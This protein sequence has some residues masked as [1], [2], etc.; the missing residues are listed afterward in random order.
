M[1]FNSWVFAVFFAAFLA[2]HYALRSVNLRNAWILAASYFFYGWLSPL[3]PVL[4]V[5]ATLVSYAAARAIAVSPRKKRWLALGVANGLVLLSVFKYG[6]F[7]AANLNALLGL[8]GL[9][10]AVGPPGKLFPV[11][12]SFY[13]LLII[14]YLVDVARGKA[15]AEKNIVRYAAFTAFF[16]YL[17]AGPIERAGG[18]LP[19]LARAPGLKASNIS[20]GLSLFVVGLF[21][22]VALADFLA[23][24]VNK[25]YGQ[26]AEAAGLTLLVAT[27]AFA[28][29]IYFDFSG[30]TDLA[31]GAAKMMGY[32]L[33]LNFNN[34][35]LADG[36][37]DFWRRWHISLSSWIRDYLYFPLAGR[38]I[39]AGLRSYL[40]MTAAILLAG[41]WHGAAWTFV[42]WGAL[43]ALG[44][45]AGREL[46]LTDFYR[47]RLPRPV[48][49]FFV[50]HWVCL[51][52]I[53]FRAATI[54][55][56]LLILRRILSLTA[57]DPRFPLAAALL[58]GLVL[59]YQLI[60]RSKSRRLL[61]TPAVRIALV[62]AMMLY[63]AFFS[64][65]GYEKFYYFRF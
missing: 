2:V 11:G 40:A 18:M 20:E 34:P 29:Q 37:G 64:T 16:P 41:L 9:E 61:C 17:L 24:Y 65:P 26:P 8:A 50:F 52:W 5:Y 57:G 36:M 46:E 6:A 31:R 62:T 28:W 54:E 32:D 12:V 53:F 49:Q 30:Y 14:G 44:R 22:K 25:V 19:Q 58:V 3:Y 45:A 13:S 42:V 47:H 59:A 1:L 60:F 38:T 33:S 51:A 35:Y 4:L 39:A 27:Y 21:K 63:L 48:K 56:A 7:L 15:P 23:L 55:D 10:A 43:H